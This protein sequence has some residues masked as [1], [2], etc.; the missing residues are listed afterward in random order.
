MHDGP[1]LLRDHVRPSRAAQLEQAGWPVLRHE[2]A[3]QS[4]E[5]VTAVMLNAVVP[6]LSQRSG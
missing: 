4:A 3:D 6:L 1:H 5:A 2:V